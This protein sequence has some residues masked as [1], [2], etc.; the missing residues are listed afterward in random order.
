V[1]S[2]NRIL[3]EHCVADISEYF[4]AKFSE[5]GKAYLFMSIFMSH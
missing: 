3:I 2:L 4:K 1:T 5:I